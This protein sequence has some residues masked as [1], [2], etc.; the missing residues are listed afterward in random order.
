MYFRLMLGLIGLSM[1]G[2]SLAWAGIYSPE[3]PPL[4]QVDSQGQAVALPFDQFRFALA[5]VMNVPVATPRPTR[6]YE[7]TMTRVEAFQTRGLEQLTPEEKIIYSADLIRLRRYDQAL[8]L[9][10]PASRRRGAPFALQSQLALTYFLK[11]QYAQ[12]RSVQQVSLSVFPEQMLEYTTAQ[13]AWYRN[14]ERDYLLKLMLLRDL[15]NRDRRGGG[16]GRVSEEVD[17]LFTEPGAP[18]IRLV[19][20]SGEYEPGT[21]ATEEQKKLPAD[22]IAIVQQLVLW[23]PDDT[24]LYWLLG[25]LYNASGNLD[26]ALR[27][28]NECVDSRRYQNPTLSMHRRIVKQAWEEQPREITTPELLGSGGNPAK[29]TDQSNTLGW[30]P[31]WETVLFVGGIGGGV[32]LLLVWLQIRELRRRWRRRAGR[33]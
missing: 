3:D 21:L 15:E 2:T 26:A 30:L 31:D 7:E 8:N 10:Q 5:K 24:R 29:T 33:G 19:G 14:L 1:G 18:P 9:L 6:E 16:F 20:A 22:A 23:M 4:F 13:L 32:F 17:A 11:Q 28:F 27:I 12:A 25:E